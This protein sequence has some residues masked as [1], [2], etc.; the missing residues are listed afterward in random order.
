MLVIVVAASVMVFV[1]ATGLFAALTRPQSF[2][3]EA[4]NLE[5]SSFGPVD[6]T[7]NVT[8]F[9]RNTGTVPVTLA[10]YYVKSNSSQYANSAWTGQASIPPTGLGRPQILISAACSCTNTGGTFTYTVGLSYTITIVST[11]GS[12]FTFNVVRYS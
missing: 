2:Q 3:S 4:L 7:H 8:L 9:L 5:F 12:Y 1:Y 6:P 11:R 10:S